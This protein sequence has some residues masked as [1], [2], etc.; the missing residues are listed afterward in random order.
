M[1]RYAKV[2]AH[3][4]HGTDTARR[5]YQHMER[6][7]QSIQAFD[8]IVR[9]R[10]A[11]EDEEEP[12]MQPK[13]KR[14]KFWLPEEEEVLRKE[15]SLPTLEECQSFLEK[16]HGELFVGKTAKDVQYKC[17]TVRRR[18]AKKEHERFNIVTIVS[19]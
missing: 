13:L 14:R 7:L 11:D 1:T 15:F 12:V 9:K 16:D 19:I 17:R 18:E 4:T 8:T 5:Y 3:M 6:K 2:A 10:S